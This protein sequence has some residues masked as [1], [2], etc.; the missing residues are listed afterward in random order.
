MNI[1]FTDYMYALSRLNYENNKQDLEKRISVK[2]NERD[3]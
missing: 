3:N 1:Y 2:V